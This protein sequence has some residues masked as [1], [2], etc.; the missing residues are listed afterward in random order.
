M[1]RYA[2]MLLAVAVVVMGRLLVSGALTSEVFSC[3]LGVPQT[4]RADC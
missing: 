3:P 4:A 1:L 2:G